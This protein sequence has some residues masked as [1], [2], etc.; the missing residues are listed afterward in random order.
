MLNDQKL[1]NYLEVS[2]RTNQF[3][4]Q[5]VRE[6]RDPLLRMTRK[7][8]KMEEK[9]PVLRRSKHVLFMKKLLNMIE[10]G[11]PLLVVTQVTSQ[12]TSKQCWTRWTWT[13]EVQD[14]HI[15]LWSRRRVPAFEIW[16]RNLRTTQIDSLFNKIY[17]KIK[18]IT[19][20][21]QNQRKWCW[22]WATSNC[23]N[24]SRRIPKRSAQ[25]AC[26]TGV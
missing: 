7:L 17:D 20:L 18:A 6:R 5:V 23:L 9:R 24:C 12:V 26:H 4:I 14:C 8:C 2:N 10:R 1:G 3:Q 11:N 15:L 22:K 21:V 25:H 19:R 16:F 13:S